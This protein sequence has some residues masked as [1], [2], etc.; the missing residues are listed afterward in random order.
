MDIYH[1]DPILM[2]QLVPTMVMGLAILAGR[3]WIAENA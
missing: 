3:D 2:F 1:F